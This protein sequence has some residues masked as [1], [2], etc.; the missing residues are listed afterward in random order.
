MIDEEMNLSGEEKPVKHI[1]KVDQEVLDN[2]ASREY[3]NNKSVVDASKQLL[4][5]NQQVLKQ[6]QEEVIEKENRINDLIRQ[7]E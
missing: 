6:T 3:E 4:E 1:Q 5:I 7:L 2:N